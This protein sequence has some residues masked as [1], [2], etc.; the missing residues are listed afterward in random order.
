LLAQ[1]YDLEHDAFTADVAMY[2]AI[3][4]QTDGP[5]LELGCGTGRLVQALVRAGKRAVG[6]DDD[7]AMLARAESRL[8]A[9]GVPT[10]RWRLVQV[11]VRQL[12][13]RERF[14]LVLA[15][16]DFLGYFADVGD[17]LAVLAVA[18]AHLRRAGRLVLDVTHPP[19]AFL[20]QPEGLL[21][22][23]WTRD[24]DDGGALTKWWVRE[25]DAG[26]QIAA[27][28]AYYDLTDADGI[29]RR[30]VQRLR[31]RYFFRFE[32]A[33]LLERAGLEVSGIYGG[34]GLEPFTANSP[35]LIV[36]AR[37]TSHPRPQARRRRLE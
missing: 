35:R 29:L 8:R 30:V 28:T 27:L 1:Y 3:A 5:V 31:L 9:T 23:Q 16:L 21:V 33:L 24:T 2:Q 12:V 32:L 10:R 22:H 36:E 34:Y 11:D 13:L 18:R 20:D 4:Q 6:V 15:P 25:L 14:G 19:G 17:Q 7:P 37:A 26:T